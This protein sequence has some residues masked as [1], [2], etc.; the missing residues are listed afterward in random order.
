MKQAAENMSYM[1]VTMD[2]VNGPPKKFI[3]QF[4]GAELGLF[5]QYM[6][7][8]LLVSRGV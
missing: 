2:E 1:N 6:I 5:I 3:T 7:N 4:T 8:F